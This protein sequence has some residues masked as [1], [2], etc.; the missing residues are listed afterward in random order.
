[1]HQHLNTSI[2]PSSHENINAI[3]AGTGRCGSTMLSNLLREH[4]AV[5]SLSEF[6]IFLHP[7]VFNEDVLDAAQFWK[8]IGE[9]AP[10]LRLYLQQEAPLPEFLYLFKVPSSRFTGETGVPSILLVTLPHLTNDYE[11]VYD[12]L[13]EVVQG[14]PR[15]RIAGHL[16]RLIDW[17]KHRFGRRVCIERSGASLALV[18]SLIRLFPRAKFVH[19]IRDGRACAWSMS[20]HFAFRFIVAMN[21]PVMQDGG[22]QAG[23][24]A[25]SADQQPLAPQQIDFMHIVSGPIPLSA[26]G[27][28]WSSL[29]ISGVQ[30]L[31]VLPE[32]QILT[33]RY[34]DIVAAPQPNLARLID[35]IDPSLQNA[36]W[37]ARASTLVEHRPSGWE[38]LPAAEREAF[39]RACQ[40]GQAVLDLIMQEGMHSPGLPAL[41]QHGTNAPAEP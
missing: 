19:L 9:P 33:I 31:S 40:P 20:R 18:S 29:I 36:D 37:L 26:F 7:S 4:P 27:R 16:D 3:V 23:E 10:H 17:L 25:A 30:A 35:F 32:E 39:E 1:M 22:G 28:Y 24:G 15:D 14:F 34:E 5:L 21:I 2:L 13:R 6:F 41:L 38:H 8:V 11:A 12:E